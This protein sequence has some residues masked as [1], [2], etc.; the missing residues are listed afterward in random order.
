MRKPTLLE[1]SLAALFGGIIGGFLTLQLA[2]LTWHWLIWTP[3]LLGVLVGYWGR[4]RGIK[5]LLKV[6]SRGRY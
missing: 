1:R 5:G 3:V 2:F 4:D 6:A